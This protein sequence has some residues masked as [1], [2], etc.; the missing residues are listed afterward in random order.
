LHRWLPLPPGS[1]E[2]GL[3]AEA[4]SHQVALAPGA[5]FAVLPSGP[6][7]RI[8]IGGAPVRDLEQALR[9]LSAILPPNP[10]L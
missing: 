8:S 9:I 6:A 3:L 1:D 2:P 4:L 10:A 7:L 5:G